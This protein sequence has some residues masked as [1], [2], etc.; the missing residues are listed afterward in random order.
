MK[1]DNKKNINRMSIVLLLFSV[2][3]VASNI[4]LIFTPLYHK[5]ITFISISILIFINFFIIKK[6]KYSELENSGEIITI[7][8]K[9]LIG[10]YKFYPPIEIP[11]VYIQQI[12]ILRY[13][14]KSTIFICF[15]PYHGNKTKV[16]KYSLIGIN[17]NE[18]IKFS[19]SLKELNKITNFNISI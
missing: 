3:C 5:A 1:I 11:I 9:H 17:K 15:T 13:S 8:T 19:S 12:D 16:L 7:K 14:I 6:V 10:F 2:I 4:V 18:L